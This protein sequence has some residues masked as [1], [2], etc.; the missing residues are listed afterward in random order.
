MWYEFSTIYFLMLLV[1]MLLSNKILMVFKCFVQKKSKYFY[2]TKI[3]L[4]LFYKLIFCFRLSLSLNKT[5]CGS[6]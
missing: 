5:G 2:K 3:L 1:V 4:K 6:G